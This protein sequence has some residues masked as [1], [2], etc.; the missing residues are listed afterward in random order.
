ML[1][2]I[3]IIAL[4]ATLAACQ[5][6]SDLYGNGSLILQPVVAKY[7][8]DIRSKG[9]VALESVFMAVDKHSRYLGYSYCPGEPNGCIDARGNIPGGTA[10]EVCNK[11]GKYDCA[12][13]AINNSVVWQGPIYLRDKDN[14]Q[15]LPYHGKWAFQLEQPSSSI[16]EL[17]GKEGRLTLSS[18]DLGENCTVRL[19]P[20]GS[21]SGRLAVSCD[22]GRAVSGDYS[23]SG[24]G[25]F[26]GT[27][28]NNQ[29]VDYKFQLDI[30]SG[31]GNPGAGYFE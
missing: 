7:T 24:K 27:G 18:P 17:I 10:V 20:T 9:N 28:K 1:K 30:A 19:H 2:I 23:R 16:G 15:N 13:F 26:R 29:G 5:K 21:V 6:T 8:L 4:A 25:V 11:D 22:N 14:Q 12:L 3:G 31:K